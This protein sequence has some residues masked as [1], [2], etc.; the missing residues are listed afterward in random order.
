MT[1]SSLGGNAIAEAMQDRYVRVAEIE[2]DPV[3]LDDAWPGRADLFGQIARRP[4][5]KP[6]CEGAG[7]LQAWPLGMYLPMTHL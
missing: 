6:P 1:A 5:A 2:I 4:K 3:K 7:A